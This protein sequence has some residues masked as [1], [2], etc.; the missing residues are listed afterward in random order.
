MKPLLV[1]LAG[2]IV[3][4][5][6]VLI[7]AGRL[8]YWPAWVYGAISVLMNVLMRMVLH[9][10]PALARER[11]K[12]GPGAKAWDKKLLS[13]GGLLTLAILV[14]AGLDTGRYHWSSQ[15]S[16]AWSVVGVLLSMAGMGVF[17]MALRKNAFFSAVVRIQTD[18]GQTVC[19]SGPYS[20]V[21][22]PGNAGMIIGTIALPLI[23]MSA[24]S[25]IPAF[26]SVL[27]IIAR[28]RLEDDV[29]AKELDGYRDYQRATPYRLV[30]GIW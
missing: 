26:L 11:A 13:L 24:W 2:N 4:F 28:T 22:H 27:L 8:D 29:L 6:V 7:A 21:R 12:S 5:G 19:D 15:V 25:A 10:N 23:F 14:V 16:W 9:R 3:F 17:L 1:S 18:R 20:V 30:P